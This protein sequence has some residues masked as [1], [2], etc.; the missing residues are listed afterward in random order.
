MDDIT[1]KVIA[2]YN[3]PENWKWSTAK[4][5]QVENGILVTG[6]CDKTNMNEDRK[7]LQNRTYFLEDEK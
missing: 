3:L 7:H 5:E 6:K 4:R 1:K 2:K